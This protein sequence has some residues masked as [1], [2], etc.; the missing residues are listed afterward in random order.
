MNQITNLSQLKVDLTDYFDA[1][2]L[3]KNDLD[4]TLYTLHEIKEKVKALK[5]EAAKHGMHEAYFH[6]LEQFTG[7]LEYTMTLRSGY[8]ED[9]EMRIQKQLD[10]NG[11]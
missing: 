11:E 2:C 8:W 9:E 5:E 4:W 3:A 10:G 1:V 6:S 7:I